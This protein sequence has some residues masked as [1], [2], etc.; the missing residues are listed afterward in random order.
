[1]IPP[2][3]SKPKPKT[4]PLWAQNQRRSYSSIGAV[5]TT[6]G[7]KERIT[8]RSNELLPEKSI[9]E[10]WDDSAE[11]KASFKLWLIANNRKA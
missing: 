3:F 1:M 4:I 10:V 6:E 8:T 2:R 11:D 7:I 5:K 9:R